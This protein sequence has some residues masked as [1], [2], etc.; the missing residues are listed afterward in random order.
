M[1]FKMLLRPR[2]VASLT[3]LFYSIAGIAFLFFPSI[4]LKE[5][6][7][8]TGFI[9]WNLMLLL[10]GSASL[11]GAAFKSYWFEIIGIPGV[12][13][14]LLV[15]G[16]SIFYLVPNSDSPGVLVGLASIMLA[17]SA[18]TVGRGWEV[19]RVTLISSRLTR[20]EKFTKL[21]GE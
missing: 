12:V 21:G 11:L 2:W 8:D 18:G 15:Y 9:I 13:T 10:G 7:G 3:Y 1:G 4:G 19:L 17:A 6:L 14:G 20:R 5:L 16:I